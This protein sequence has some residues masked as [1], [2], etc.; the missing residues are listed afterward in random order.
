MIGGSIFTK[1][2]DLS[3]ENKAVMNERA[4]PDITAF[5]MLSGKIASI[6]KIAFLYVC[7]PVSNSN[8]YRENFYAN[9]ENF[10]TILYYLD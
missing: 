8:F 6:R 10:L 4:Y 9:N 7:F 5:R 3:T 2:L 1:R